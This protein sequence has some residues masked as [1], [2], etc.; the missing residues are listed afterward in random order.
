[1]S[2]LRDIPLPTKHARVDFALARVEDRAHTGPSPGPSAARDCLEGR[3]GDDRHAGGPGEPL[4]DAEAHPQAGERAG[5]DGDRNRV[6]I[7]ELSLAARVVSPR[8]AV[9]T[10]RRGFPSSSR[11]LA[12]VIPSV[13]VTP[14]LAVQVAVSIPSTRTAAL[15]P[16]LG[17]A[18][19]RCRRR[20]PSGR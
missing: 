10:R 1:M 6:E 8:S 4:G 2:V 17:D 3:N 14:T 13:D 18:Q 15:S 11:S 9:T 19:C 16:N 20:R 7:G 5:T 12:R